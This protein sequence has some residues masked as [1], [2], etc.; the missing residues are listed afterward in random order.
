LGKI[1]I[2]IAGPNG[3]VDWL[4]AGAKIFLPLKV[5]DTSAPQKQR[6]VSSHA[7]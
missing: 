6:P 7:Q 4:E 2:Y 3:E 1:E 5:A